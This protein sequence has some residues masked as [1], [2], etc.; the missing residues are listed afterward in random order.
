MQ[1]QGALVREQGVEFAIIVVKQFIL[2]DSFRSKKIVSQFQLHFKRP[3]VLMSQ[4]SRGIP[5]YLGRSD[6]V[7]FLA[8]VPL[9][10]FTW[11]KFTL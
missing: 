4:D 11:R 7:R 5:T 3:V 9:N 2:N 6:L 8:H 10:A 1:L